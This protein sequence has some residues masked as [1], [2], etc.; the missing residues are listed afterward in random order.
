MNKM[1]KVCGSE[2]YY[3][4]M[5]ETELILLVSEHLHK[6]AILNM[7]QKGSR[8]GRLMGPY[9]QTFITVT[10]QMNFFFSPCNHLV[11]VI[12]TNYTLA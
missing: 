5:K 6:S 12:F 7:N 2:L 3:T 4:D 8:G 10:Q 1:T 9:I 11:G